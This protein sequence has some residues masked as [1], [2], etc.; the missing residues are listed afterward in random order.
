MARRS[1]STAALFIALVLS[2]GSA[3]A[4]DP[5]VESREDF[6][7]GVT[8]VHEGKLVE[9]RE[10]FEKAYAIFAHPSILLNLGIMRLRTG[11]YVLAEDDLSHFLVNDGG[12]TSDEV[13]SARSALSETRDHLGTMRLSISPN[14]AQVTVDGVAV[15]VVQAGAT[16][17]RTTT[18][19]HDVKI[20][21]DDYDPAE[22]HI[23]VTRDHLAE[24]TIFLTPHSGAKADIAIYD[25]PSRNGLPMRSLVGWGLVGFGG[26]AVVGGILC[27][28]RAIS[29]SED[30]NNQRPQDP[31][32]KSTGL[33]FRTTSDILFATALV[34][35]GV[36]AYLL[37]TAPKTN[38]GVAIGPASIR[39]RFAF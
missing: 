23:M 15:A 12:A 32:D 35:G 20:S 5:R 17:I 38:A 9:A 2:A 31:S 14:T 18:G 36:G 29:L 26:V 8:L 7:R 25:D 21:A 11:E 27:C 30:Y 1:A 6:R 19:L 22:E 34:T 3:R 39:L 24:R 13:A 10:A 37:L 4:A 28:V 33:A 16:E